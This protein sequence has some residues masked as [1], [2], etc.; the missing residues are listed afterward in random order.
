MF[1]LTLGT[2]ELN[3]IARLQMDAALLYEGVNNALKLVGDQYLA[4]VYRLAAE[5]FHLPE[6]DSGIERKLSTLESIYT[7]LQDL[8]GRLRMEVLEWIIIILF[9]V[10]IVLPFLPW[11]RAK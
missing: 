3:R 1:P 8:Q 9:V 10:S 11:G 5:R 7:K 4:R 6:R 2:R